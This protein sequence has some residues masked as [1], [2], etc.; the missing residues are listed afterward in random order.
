M[1]AL[2]GAETWG[3]HH[4]EFKMQKNPARK[5]KHGNMKNI[6]K[7]TLF[8]YGG[9]HHTFTSQISSVQEGPFLKELKGIF[10][11]TSKRCF[12]SPEPSALIAS[13]ICS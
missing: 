3:I 2:K 5:A 10:S 9:V 4:H 1:E 6:R 11:F 13:P 12:C 7:T 8:A